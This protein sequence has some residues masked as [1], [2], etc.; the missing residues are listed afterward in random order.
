M[1]TFPGRSFPDRP[2]IHYNHKYLTASPI[3]RSQN[4]TV[5]NTSLHQPAGDLPQNLMSQLNFF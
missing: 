2:S 3:R 4:F 5:A 1:V